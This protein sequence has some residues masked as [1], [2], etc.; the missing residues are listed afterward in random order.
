[1]NRGAQ[2]WWSAAV[3]NITIDRLSADAQFVDDG[4]NTTGL[5]GQRHDSVGEMRDD[6]SADNI[7]PV[8]IDSGRIRGKEDLAGR[9]SKTRDMTKVFKFNHD[10][11]CA[12]LVFWKTMLE[13]MKL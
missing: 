8:R 1:M 4:S 12:F 11:E 6:S 3:V 9:K 10:S 2:Q 13:R 7:L 5:S